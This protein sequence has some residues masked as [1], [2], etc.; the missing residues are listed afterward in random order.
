MDTC[1]TNVIISYFL[2]PLVIIALYL[3]LIYYSTLFYILI[4]ILAILI[5]ISNKSRKEEQILTILNNSNDNGNPNDHHIV[6]L[7]N[8]LT[9]NTI[10]LQ[11]NQSHLNQF[12]SEIDS[13]SNQHQFNQNT[14]ESTEPP[15]Y[16]MVTSELPSYEE[17]VQQENFHRMHQNLVLETKNI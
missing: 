8:E 10:Y 7:S 14:I 13:N 15:P 9:T 17:A 16:Y 12:S 2:I 1:T 5:Y 6:I 3:S 11:S 4:Y